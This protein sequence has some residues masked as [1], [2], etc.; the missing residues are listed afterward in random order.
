MASVRNTL[1]DCL[2]YFE[3]AP[4]AVKN[5][6]KLSDNKEALS[7]LY[8]AWQWE[9]AV[10]KSKDTERK[11]KA[12]EQRESHLELAALFIDNKEEAKAL[13]EDVYK[14]RDRIIQASSLVASTHSYVLI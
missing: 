7:A 5:C 9:K 11:H 4:Q 13:K 1:P 10:I 2:T 12:I 8:L 6:Q 14:E 3:N